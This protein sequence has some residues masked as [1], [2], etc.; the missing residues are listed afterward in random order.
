MPLFIAH[1]LLALY[2]WRHRA[3]TG[4][5][6]PRGKGVKKRPGAGLYAA[7]GISTRSHS[8]WL[9]GR[10]NQHAPE[11]RPIRLLDLTL[12]PLEGFFAIGLALIL[13]LCEVIRFC[14]HDRAGTSMSGFLFRAYIPQSNHPIVW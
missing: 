1:D 9:V 6:D 10:G 11:S 5:Q 13:T 4:P 7:L 2:L 12:A 14:H 3:K 8:R